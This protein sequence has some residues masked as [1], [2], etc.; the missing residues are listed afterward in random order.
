MR[1]RLL[2][3]APLLLGAPCVTTAAAQVRPI[4]VQRYRFEVTLP[5]RGKL[6]QVT[7]RLVATRGAGADTLRL[8]L[9]APMTVGAVTLGCGA[10]PAAAPFTH[11]GKVI[12][13]PLGAAS[14]AVNASPDPARAPARDSLCVTVRYEGEPADGLIITTDSAG[15]FR[16]FADNWPDRGRHWLAAVDHPSDKALAEFVVDAPA[17][18]RVVSNG[19]QKGQVDVPGARPRRRTTWATSE[20]IPT[21]LMVIAAAPLTETDLGQT[22]CGLAST[23]R[24]VR[25]LVYTAPEQARF[26]PGHFAEADSILTFFARTVGPFP[27]EQLAHLQSSTRF[28]GMENA[29]AIFYADRLFRTPNGVSTR[30]IAHETAHQ[31]FGDAVTE[32]EWGHL[33]LSEGFATYFAA[34]YTEHAR[35]DSAFRAELAGIRETVLKAEVVAQRPVID[36]AQTDY[37]KLLNA[38]SYQK[39]GLVLHMLR[40]QLGD[41]AFFRAIRQYH[42]AYRHGTALTAHLQHFAER[43]FGDELGWFFD[44]WLRKP[45]W[46]ELEVSDRFDATEKRVMLTVRQSARFGAYRMRLPVEVTLADGTVRMTYADIPAQQEATV[47]V[48]LSLNEAPKAIRLDPRADLLVVI[49]RQ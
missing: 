37:L 16:A 26:M 19:T 44:Q 9:L 27:Y 11:D 1:H 15:R 34:L 49:T 14:A 31:W 2:F 5:E 22:A 23:G 21:Y 10:A 33:W 41:S 47:P 18:L 28:G 29:G 30:L 35:G 38:N 12:T 43:E 32:A 20:P 4:D 39:G 36:S 40:R 45:G 13:I 17:A 7:A 25:Q 8:D 48:R 3:L 6:V 24:C 46:A 42:A